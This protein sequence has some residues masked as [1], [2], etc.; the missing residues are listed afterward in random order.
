[1]QGWRAHG[2]AIVESLRSGRRL[3]VHC[4]AGLGRSGMVAAK[5]LTTFGM[6]ADDA[7]ALVR[8]CRPGTIETQQQADYVRSGDA[9]SG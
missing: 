7:I 5:I 4:A 8:K 3:I 2:P 9:L 1:M 6:S